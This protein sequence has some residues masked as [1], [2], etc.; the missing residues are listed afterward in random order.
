[1]F[2]DEGWLELDRG[3]ASLRGQLGPT[4]LIISSVPAW[5]YLRTGN[6]AIMPPFESDSETEARLLRSTGARFVFIETMDGASLTNSYLR[7]VVNGPDWQIRFGNL[8]SP[9]RIYERK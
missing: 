5:I 4:D 2:Y 8:S 7:A 9:V 3:I 1:L 6:Q